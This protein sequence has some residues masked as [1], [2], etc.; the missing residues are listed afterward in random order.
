MISLAAYLINKNEPKTSEV[1]VRTSPPVRPVSD[2]DGDGGSGGSGNGSG[3]GNG[4]RAKQSSSNLGRTFV[5]GVGIVEPAGE[6]ISVG[7][8]LPGI[9]AE[10]RVNPGDDVEAGQTLFVLDDRTARA[11]IAV[12]KVQ[13]AAEEAKLQDLVGQVATQRARVDAASARVDLAEAT[14]RDANRELKRAE[15]LAL[16][17]AISATELDQNRL[18][19]EVAQAQSREAAANYRQELANLQLISSDPDGPKILVQKIAIEQA[20]AALEREQVV[21]AQHTIVA[22]RASRVLQVKV[23]AGE[24][25]PAAVLATPV[26]TLGVV[27]PLHVRVEIDEADITRFSGTAKAYA[28]VRGRPDN[29]FP[30]TYVRTEPYVIPKKTLTGSVSERVDTR[31]LQVIY[32]LKPEALAAWPGQQIDVYIECS[33]GT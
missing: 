31:V 18:S 29:R 22:P 8:Q 17:N 3:S 9:V 4:D 13:L 26:I 20:R 24:Y 6:A 19:V 7:S 14:L 28:S 16:S 21:L 10:V 33:D 30:M 25:V 1:S 12:A 2:G 11:N 23:R 15:E 27:K 5:G 32:S